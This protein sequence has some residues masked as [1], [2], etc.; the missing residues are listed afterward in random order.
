M[1]KEDIAILAQLLT[2]MKDAI[3]E[4]EEAEKNK[5]AEKL[6]AAKREILNF[7]TQINSIL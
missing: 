6:A 1:K 2:S 3:D 7:Q 5:D 4:L